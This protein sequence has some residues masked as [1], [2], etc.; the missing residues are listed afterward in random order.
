MAS[1]RMPYAVLV[2]LISKY[3]DEIKGVQKK[4]EKRIRGLKE[5]TDSNQRN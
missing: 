1:C 5:H 2:I 3:I 4:V